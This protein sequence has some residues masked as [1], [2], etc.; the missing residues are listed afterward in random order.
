MG[1][2]VNV[3]PPSMIHREDDLGEQLSMQ[4]KPASALNK[5]DATHDFLSS[6]S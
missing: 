5:D 1:P 2:P 3:F 6:L 4:R